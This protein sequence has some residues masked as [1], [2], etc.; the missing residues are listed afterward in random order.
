MMGEATD[1][2]EMEAMPPE[3]DRD[4]SPSMPPTPPKTAGR[5]KIKI[6]RIEDSRNRQV[7]HL[8][9][10]LHCFLFQALW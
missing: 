1:A 6:A 3:T 4:V 10:V 5:K 8:N 7:R 2:L 9:N